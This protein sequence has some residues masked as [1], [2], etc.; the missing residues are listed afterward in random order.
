MKKIAAALIF[1]LSLS[2]CATNY[3]F[4]G[5]KYDNEESFQLAVEEARNSAL[6]QVQK[7]PTNLTNRRLVAA[8]P[9]E[10]AHY[11]IFLQRYR[12][13]NGKEATGSVLD[14]YRNLAKSNYKIGHKV[15]FEAIQKRGIYPS[16]TINEMPTGIISIEPTNE[17]DVLYITESTQ[18]S[19][20]I[21]YASTK[22]GKQAFAFDRSSGVLSTQIM[23]FIEAVQSL[24]IRE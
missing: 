22:H 3:L 13:A 16:V 17:Y 8:I 4:Q 12:S 14:Q 24:A 11:N 18:G 20:Q 23:A 21:F 19:S 2:G 15:W 5:K 6:N 10:Q 7:L 9:S 1:A